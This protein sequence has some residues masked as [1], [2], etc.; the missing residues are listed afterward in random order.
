[1]AGALNWDKDVMNIRGALSIFNLLNMAVR[2]I[3]VLREL[4]TG[5]DA[6]GLIATQ[7]HITGNFENPRAEVDPLSTIQPGLLRSIIDE[8]EGEEY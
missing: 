7:F 6:Q 5:A 4:L 1:M 8:I 2:D 3:P